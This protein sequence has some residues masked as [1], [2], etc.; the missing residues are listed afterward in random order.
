MSAEDFNTTDPFSQ[1]YNALI[2][3][4]EAQDGVSDEVKAG[5]F[6]KFNTNDPSPDKKNRADAD[7]PEWRIVPVQL[8]PQLFATSSSTL[9]QYQFAVQV[10]TGVMGAVARLFPHQWLILKA[11]AKTKEQGDTFYN[12]GL[13][14][15]VQDV[16]YTSAPVTAV[17]PN[18]GDPL[19]QWVTVIV[20]VVDMFFDT[21]TDLREVSS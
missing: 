4:L 21:D 10:C 5:N 3:A 15:F 1:V 2:E 19:N 17:D 16:R 14:E 11:L 12:L 18:T 6:I 8:N 9:A 7:Y 13:S 20:V